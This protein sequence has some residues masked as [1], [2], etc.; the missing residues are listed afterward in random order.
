[1]NELQNSG[2]LPEITKN[3]AKQILEVIKN[4]NPQFYKGKKE[5]EIVAELNTIQYFIQ[6][7][8]QKVLNKMCELAV[9]KYPKKKIEN[10]KL[11]F[12][13]NYILG[14][15]QEA[16]FIIANDI[17][18]LE[19]LWTDIETLDVVGGNNEESNKAKV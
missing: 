18:S 7:I 2:S 11:V 8:P 9:I 19:D 10:E 15:Y 5:S 3:N 6:D 1:M 13:L 4:V 17:T 12:N 16:D 14:F